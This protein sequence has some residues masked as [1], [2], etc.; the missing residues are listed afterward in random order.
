MSDFVLPQASLFLG[1][2][3]ALI[4]LY[5][6]LKGYE[7]YYQISNKGRVKSLK[8]KVHY[9][10]ILPNKPEVIIS[11]ERMKKYWKNKG[12]NV[13]TYIE[14]VLLK[15]PCVL[16]TIAVYDPKEPDI[17]RVIVSL[18]LSRSRKFEKIEE[19]HEVYLITHLGEVNFYIDNLSKLL[20]FT[21][22]TDVG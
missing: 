5:I 2:I 20:K 10:Y 18:P 1:I 7:G 16:A 11:F 15:E 4:L 6:S 8:R 21:C 17:P 14:R 19:F 12:A 9:K 3:P 22:G 13:N